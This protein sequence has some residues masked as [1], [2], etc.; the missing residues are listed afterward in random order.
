MNDKPRLRPVQT[1]WMVSASVP[2]LEAQALPDGRPQSV[3]FIG[4]FKLDHRASADS[5]AVSLVQRPGRF[6]PAKMRG[7]GPYR[8]V[9]I[10]FEN[11]VKVRE[12]EAFADL[13]VVDTSK[14]DWSLLP[15]PQELLEGETIAEYLARDEAYWLQTGLSPNPGM[16]EVEGSDWLAELGCEGRNLHHYLILGHDEFV[17]VLAEGWRWEEGQEVD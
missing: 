6:E 5:G 13:E 15:L 9:R 17:E 8:M 7:R 2:H 1:P 3:T 14:Y 10:V 16:Y 12:S 11:G 4:Y